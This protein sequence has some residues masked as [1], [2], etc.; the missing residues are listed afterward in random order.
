MFSLQTGITN[1][2]IKSQENGHP[3]CTVVMG[4]EYKEVLTGAGNV[5]FLKLN[6]NYMEWLSL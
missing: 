3:W 4:K 5:L 6:V 1:N 2:H